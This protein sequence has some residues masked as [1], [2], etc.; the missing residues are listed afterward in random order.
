M[1][2][3]RGSSSGRTGACI[4]PSSERLMNAMTLPIR[5]L[6]PRG[7]GIYKTLH[8]ANTTARRDR[9]RRSYYHLNYC[10]LNQR[11]D[12]DPLAAPPG[13]PLIELSRAFFEFAASPMHL[14]FSRTHSISVAQKRGGFGVLQ[15]WKM[16]LACL[17]PDLQARNAGIRASNQR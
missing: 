2:P 13:S 11:I 12:G 15:D 3:P 14:A 9:F 16:N 4:T 17:D 8:F 5:V 7:L 6:S 1:N 10:C